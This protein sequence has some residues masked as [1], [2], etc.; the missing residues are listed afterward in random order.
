MERHLWTILAGIQKPTA[1]EHIYTLEL[2]PEDRIAA[3]AQTLYPLPSI[4]SI[5]IEP[6]QEIDSAQWETIARLLT[7]LV[8]FEVFDFEV[9][10]PLE[11]GRRKIIYS[12]RL[13]KPVAGNSVQDYFED[14]VAR[15]DAM[16]V[17]D[18]LLHG[19]DT[20]A[21]ARVSLGKFLKKPL[22]RSEFP[23]DLKVVVV[24]HRGKII[25]ET[26]HPERDG[27]FVPCGGSNI[28]CTVIDTNKYLGMSQEAWALIKTIPKSR[29][30]IGDLTI[31]ETDDDRGCFGWIGHPKRLADPSMC[32]LSRDGT[33]DIPF[34]LIENTVNPEEL[35]TIDAAI[36][37]SETESMN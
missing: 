32:E 27:N 4:L 18:D 11:A 1:R 34:I 35:P 23:D 25:I 7:G 28:G 10:E 3:K 15:F 33:P 12:T 30:C 9:L 21:T 17:P 29:D 2:T 31:W 16:D 19:V 22:S 36:D 24:E 14:E 13:G 37:D 8:N 5:T 26:I 20:Y 6:I